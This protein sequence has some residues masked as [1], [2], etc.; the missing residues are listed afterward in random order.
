[1]LDFQDLGQ[2]LEVL[3]LLKKHYQIWLETVS[4][5]AS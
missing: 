4:Q 3:K 2:T 5:G 1:M